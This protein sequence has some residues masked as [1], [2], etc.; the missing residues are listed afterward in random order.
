MLRGILLGEDA[1][2]AG[3]GRWPEERRDA[4]MHGR[5]M[6]ANGRACGAGAKTE[7]EEGGNS[8]V[9]VAGPVAAAEVTDAAEVES[10]TEAAEVETD[11][12]E[13]DATE[14]ADA[15]EVERETDATDVPEIVLVESDSDAV[16]V[17]AT[18]VDDAAL[19]T[20]SVVVPRS[21]VT[22]EVSCAAAERVRA[23]RVLKAARRALRRTA[24]AASGLCEEGG[25]R[26]LRW[27]GESSGA[28]L[29]RL[30]R[31]AVWSVARRAR[32]PSREDEKKADVGFPA[33]PRP[34][35]AVLPPPA[36]SRPAGPSIRRARRL[37][38]HLLP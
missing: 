22:E 9:S 7:R 15:I 4:C 21:V 20:E 29:E 2:G 30:Y 6:H 35:R 24:M 18:L 28:A 17:D 32:E 23:R 26:R 16:M 12:M 10:E 13:V 11:A 34:I 37:P 25:Q 31:R 8:L 5:G 14:V 27:A 19:V 1:H 3:R 36:A 33:R 38:V